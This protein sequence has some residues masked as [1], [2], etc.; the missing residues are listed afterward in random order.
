MTLLDFV[1]RWAPA[2]PEARRRFLVDLRALLEIE[3][4]IAERR[5]LTR[6]PD[7]AKPTG[8]GQYA[9]DDPGVYPQRTGE[10]ASAVARGHATP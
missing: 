8:A 10:S 3:R 7:R 1:L 6:E 2:E 5:V 4:R 9:A